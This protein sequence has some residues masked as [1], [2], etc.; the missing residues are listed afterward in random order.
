MSQDVGGRNQQAG[1]TVVELLVALT[2]F[3]LLCTLLFGNVRF[4]L[5]AWQRGL[6]HTERVDHS[7]IVQNL[8]RRIIG[9]VYPLFINQYISK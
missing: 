4:G 6:A 5:K 2:L 3:S 1:F 7:M 8:L 9:E